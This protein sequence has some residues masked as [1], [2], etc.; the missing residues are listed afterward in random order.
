MPYLEKKFC[1]VFNAIL[2]SFALELSPMPSH[3]FRANCGLLAKAC[4]RG[5]NAPVFTKRFCRQRICPYFMIA[6]DFG[7]ISI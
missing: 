4:K 5:K 3:F 1:M 7:I 6:P 2:P